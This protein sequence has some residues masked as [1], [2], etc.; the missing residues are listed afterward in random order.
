MNI[1]K[2]TARS[3]GASPL[4]RHLITRSFLIFFFTTCLILTLIFTVIH[5]YTVKKEQERYLA[6]CETYTDNFSSHL[7]DRFSGLVASANEIFLQKWYGHYGFLTDLYQHEFDSSIERNDISTDLNARLLGMDFVTDLI[8]VVPLRDKVITSNGWYSFKEYAFFY[9]E[10]TFDISNPRAPKAEIV[11][12]ADQSVV[13][14]PDPSSRYNKGL[15]CLVISH[16]DFQRYI[17]PLLPSLAQGYQ[18]TLDGQTLASGGSSDASIHCTQTSIGLPKVNVSL[19]FPSESPEIANINTIYYLELAVTLLLSLMIS[20]LVMQRNTK[21]VEKLLSRHFGSEHYLSTVTQ[22]TEY[23]D[24]YIEDIKKREQ[25][26]LVTGEKLRDTINA[27]RSELLFSALNNAGFD[28]DS[29]TAKYIVPWAD[30][31]LPYIVVL[32]EHHNDR[33]KAISY[34]EYEVFETLCEKI[35]DKRLIHHYMLY[36]VLTGECIIIFWLDPDNAVEAIR[37]L[38]EDFPE[39]VTDEYVILTSQDDHKELP[40]HLSELR[41]CYLEIKRRYI[42][43]Y[44]VTSFLSVV[45]ELQI[46]ECIQN[47]KPLVLHDLL[48]TMHDEGNPSNAVMELLIRLAKEYGVGYDMMLHSFHAAQ[49]AGNTELMWNMVYSFA[50]DICRM[51]NAEKKVRTDES[52]ILIK[53]VIDETYTSPDMSIKYLS[54]LFKLEESIVSRLFKNTYGISFSDYLFDLRMKLACELL[55]SDKAMTVAE[56]SAAVGYTNLSGFRRAFQ[57]YQGVSPNAY[58]NLCDEEQ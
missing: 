4:G 8:V 43:R 40:C 3:M 51:L 47:D 29:D 53:K 49:Q 41:D 6:E 25:S 45:T 24:Q 7:F 33:F 23:I 48:E 30:E 2:R 18:I 16:N 1:Q 31:D 56:I 58:R 32:A 44:R 42:S 36:K 10:V 52:A 9:N 55:R 19:Y 39:S 14:V 13:A 5:S 26:S 50:S 28:W 27:M 35:S 17:T 54:D 21:P 46:I 57:R 11:E 22:A 38:C 34:D 37:Y 20:F 15:V 12:K